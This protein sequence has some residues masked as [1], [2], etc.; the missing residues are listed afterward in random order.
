MHE[1]NIDGLPLRHPQLGPGLQPRHVPWLGSKLVT[2]QFAGAQSIEPHQPGLN[3]FYDYKVTIDH[4][5]HWG[6]FQYIN[7]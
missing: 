6:N 4:H 1:R 5:K 3:I 2:F 7:F